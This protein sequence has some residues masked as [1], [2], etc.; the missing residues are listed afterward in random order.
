MAS[1]LGNTWYDS[2][3]VKATKRYSHGL[4]LTYAFTWAKQL[5]N[6]GGTPDVQNRGLSKTL[7]TLDQPFVSGVG[8]NY[9]LP[10]WGKNKALSFAV[11][12]W[13]LGGFVQYASGTPI[14]PPAANLA[15][16]L[17]TLVFQTT[18]VQNRVPG[19]P[20]FT[21]DLNCHC[22]DPNKTFVLNPAA[23]AN[24]RPVSL[25]A[26]LSTAI[27]GRSAA[28]LRICPWGGC[29]GFVKR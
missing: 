19:V 4:D 10:K 15:P 1:P 3:Q 2:L 27:T 26:V 11:R 8:F 17:N 23:W 9:T 24:P 6:F 29:S 5:D 16:T 28:R 12:D 18:N 7:A 25:A 21:Q 14:A 22:F 13:T 20:L